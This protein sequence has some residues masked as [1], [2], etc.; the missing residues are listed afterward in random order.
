[1]IVDASEIPEAAEAAEVEAAVVSPADM[2]G[3][4]DLIYQIRVV[5][6]KAG[7]KSSIGS[8]FQVSEDG[9]I[10]TNYHVVSMA[11]DSPVTH[12]I[13]YLDQA[14]NSG[15]LQLLDFDVV[16]DLAVLR[17]P[18]PSTRHFEIAASRRSED[19]TDSDSVGLPSRA[20]SGVEKGEMIYALGNPHDL[21]ITLKLGA[22][23]GIVEHSYNPQILFSGS[24]NP[25]MSGG[26][27][28]LANGSVIG[29]NVATAGSDLSFLV[30]ASAMLALIEAGRTL[31]PEDYPEEIAAQ[32]VSWQQR[33]FDDLLA[34]DWARVSF[35]D[36]PALDEI[37]FDMQCWGSSN[38][39]EDDLSIVVLS[40]GC[41]SGNRLYLGDG[42]NTGHIHYSFIQRQSV[43][44]SAL[45]FHATTSSSMY[46]DNSGD[47]TKLSGFDCQSGFVDVV[48]ENASSGS[49]TISLC[50]RAY[51]ELP[52]LYDVLLLA[53]Q[54]EDTESYTAH[55]A[56]AGVPR[57]LADRFTRKFLASLG[58][59]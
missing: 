9:L 29:V 47:D 40:K 52:E 36:W 11:V 7:S 49:V 56:L 53:T 21:G 35:G 27:G 58:W 32:V 12:S 51:I 19:S 54:G 2:A 57:D 33:R 48:D 39:D 43:K 5:A 46:P 6:R 18:T 44:L 38:E 59:Q 1:M 45:R 37:R 3:Y 50:V 20:V 4:Y 31:D 25:G 15:P 14:G 13:E 8:G 34:R 17:H 22:F 16:N 55:F 42:F 24:L 10:V 23:N 26:P 41:D 28:L 30:P